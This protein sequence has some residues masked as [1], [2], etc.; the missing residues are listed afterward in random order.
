MPSDKLDN[1]KAS[2][3]SG[4][5]PELLTPTLT[6]QEVQALQQVYAGVASEHQQKLAMAT[7]VN[8]LSRANDLLYFPGGPEGD[9]ATAF[10]N[11]RAFVGQRLMY[12]LNYPIGQLEEVK[13]DE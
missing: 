13:Q 8:K 7:I 10:I 2:V 4:K 3:R 6:K 12:F 5:P 11:G 1:L 9:R